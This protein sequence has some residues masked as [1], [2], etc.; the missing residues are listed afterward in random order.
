MSRV[1]RVVGHIIETAGGLW[2]LAALG[3]RTRFHLS[4]PYWKWRQE[5]AFG[6]G[7]PA[8]AEKRRMMLDYARWAWRMRRYR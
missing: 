1:R 5:T 7:E 3:W 4:G 8:A 6:G 2:V